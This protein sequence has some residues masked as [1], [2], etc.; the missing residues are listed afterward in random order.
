MASH[1]VVVLAAAGALVA[2]VA[3]AQTAAP[4]A[5][6]PLTPVQIAL[7]CAPPPVVAN[8]P[9]DA[10]RVIGSQDVAVRSVF[11]TPELLTISGGTERGLSLGQQ[12][13]VRRI[14]K[15]A[16]NHLDKLPHQE[17]TVGWVRIV[18]VNAT[19]TI[20]SVEHACSDILV[21]DFVEPFQRPT[22]A[23]AEVMKVDTSREPDFTTTARVLYGPEQRRSAGAGEFMLIDR[24]MDKSVSLGEHYAIYRDPKVTGAPLT[25]IGEA[26]VVSIGPSMALVRINRSR[27]AVF[28][29][30]Y[31]FPRSK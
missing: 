25:S 21:G 24:G 15:T 30:D 8:M 16:E 3:A 12:Y 27:D 1:R 14:F 29:G 22:M 6:P 10:S 19:T 18:A 2:S 5:E 11:G 9:M 13:F 17:Q 20:A 31:A 26:T 4:P 7:A 28:S 23:E